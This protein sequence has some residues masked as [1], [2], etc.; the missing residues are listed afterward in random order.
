MNV[1]PSL[2]AHRPRSSYH[3]DRAARTYGETL[4]RRRDQ[5]ADLWSGRH[6]GRLWT[7]QEIADQIGI[8]IGM[9]YRHIKALRA[10]GDPRA[11]PR[12]F[13]DSVTARSPLRLV[14]AGE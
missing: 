5:I 8:E 10:D 2:L 6:D 4:A 14:E 3:Q 7:A 11:A 12:P 13:P 1:K 9:V